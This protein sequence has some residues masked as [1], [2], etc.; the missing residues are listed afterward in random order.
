MTDRK[1]STDTV[2]ISGHVKGVIFDV[3]LIRDRSPIWD[4]LTREQ[5]HSVLS[6][7]L[8]DDAVVR[9]IECDNLVLDTYLE[10]L[11]AGSSPIPDDLAF[12]DGLDDPQ[13]TNTA[14]NNEVHRTFVGDVDHDGAQMLTSTLLSQSE[15]NGES[16]NE[17]GLASG[18]LLTH[19]VLDEPDR[20]D[21][22][23]GNM[24]IIWN[25]LIDFGREGES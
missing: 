16:I 21:E 25:Y 20:I 24:A 6:S 22:K 17:V 4:A 2:S 19:R 1:S 8:A 12:G 5:R 18:D 3:S 10:S 15:A 7:G 13:P 11:A 14:L 9:V 23:T